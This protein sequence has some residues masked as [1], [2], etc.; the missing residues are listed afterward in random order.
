M[1]SLN[2]NGEGMK[3]V[4]GNL[5]CLNFYSGISINNFLFKDISIHCNI[6]CELIRIMKLN[7]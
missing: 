5:H 7:N 4:I 6:T 2:Q 1:L 3:I